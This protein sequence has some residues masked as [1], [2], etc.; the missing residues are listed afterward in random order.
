MNVNTFD[1]SVWIIRSM[2]LQNKYL[3]GRTHMPVASKTL[4]KTASLKRDSIESAGPTASISPFLEHR[5]GHVHKYNTA[6]SFV[7]H[8]GWV[9]LMTCFQKWLTFQLPRLH[10]QELP[11]SA[12]PLWSETSHRFYTPK[13]PVWHFLLKAGDCQALWRL[14]LLK[15][16]T[17]QSWV[18]THTRTSALARTA[19]TW[20]AGKYLAK[21]KNEASSRAKVCSG[22]ELWGGGWLIVKT[23][24]IDTFMYLT[25]RS[26]LYYY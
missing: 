7:I 4:S 6:H 22:E 1:T 8:S 3:P 19:I 11:D 13:P 17:W 21:P 14:V 24:K 23:V 18:H 26:F 16:S 25:H 9:S 5:H 15:T 12:C 20:K 10:S 2:L